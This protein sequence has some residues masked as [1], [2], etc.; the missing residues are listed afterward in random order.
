MSN[1]VMKQNTR[2]FQDLRRLIR[3][4]R[5]EHPVNYLTRALEMM[6]DTNN[7]QQGFPHFLRWEP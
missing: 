7:I 6:R 5:E 3:R 4:H 2:P 1:S